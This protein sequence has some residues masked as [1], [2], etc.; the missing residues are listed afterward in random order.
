[1][2]VVMLIVSVAAFAVAAWL[3]CYL[4][5]RDARK[6]LLRRMS[7]GLLGYALAIACLDVPVLGTALLGVP[8]VAWT[9]VLLRLPADRSASRQDVWWL[10]VYVPVM[11]AAL[12]AAWSDATA[13]KAAVF[14][15]LA[16]GLGG[17]FALTAR[18]QFGRDRA[19]GLLLAITVLLALGMAALLLGLEVGPPTLWLVAVGVD[20]VVFGLIVAW[21]DALD[22][23]Q[24][25]RADML[26]SAAAAAATASL[27]GGQVALAMI[28]GPGDTGVLVAL[29]YG[30][31]G[32]AI[33]VQVL[34]APLQRIAD[35]V[36]LPESVRRDRAELRDAVDALP[37]RGSLLDVDD[38]EFAR[39]TRRALSNYAELGRL[40]SSPLTALPVIDERLAARRADDL[41]LE[42]AAELKS[43]LRESIAR[44]KPEGDFGVNDEWRHYN[45][46]Y[47]VYV[48]GLRPYNQRARHAGLSPDARKALEWFRTAVPQR[49]LHN[50]QNAAARLVAD[51]LRGRAMSK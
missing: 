18:R 9:G 17:A 45:S 51:A 5:A 49:S 48:V 47:Y 1:M 46:L 8:A 30:C 15:V 26:R 34:A 33:A 21:Y 23:G 50:W 24:R 43:L 29:L 42:R 2:D 7:A 4:L 19:A 16:A 12:A 44:L 31:V 25:L 6:P 39:L 40:V 10:R 36:A 22:E 27:F 38:A 37:R 32:G 35:R 13:S 41:P 28:V 11:S 20:L 3:G 14:A